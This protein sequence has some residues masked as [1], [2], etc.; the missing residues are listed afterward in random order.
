[1]RPVAFAKLGVVC[2]VALLASSCTLEF[3]LAPNEQLRLTVFEQGHAVKDRR[4]SSADG[5][6]IATDRWLAA[7][8]TGW[9]YAFATRQ[10]RLY[11]RGNNFYINVS[12]DEVAVKYCRGI[13]N[14]HFWVK[15][16]QRL[17]RQITDELNRASTNA[18][19]AVRTESTRSAP[20]SPF[21][22]RKIT[23]K[24]IPA[25]RQWSG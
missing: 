25:L 8:P 21:H 9:S 15:K 5:V 20:T 16:D 12:E 23:A 13:F 14:C 11:I 6:R 3:P 19:G 22:D 7:N 4:L 10:P 24:E 1:M 18:T 2:V 17:F